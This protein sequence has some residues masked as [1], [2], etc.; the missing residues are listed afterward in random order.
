MLCIIYYVETSTSPISRCMK[1][2]LK[3]GP[4]RVGSTLRWR[5]S[6]Q[7]QTTLLFGLQGM[8]SPFPPSLIYIISYY[9]VRTD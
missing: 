4:S 9:R 2:V 7:I 6:T 5:N 3:C 8:A 1:Y